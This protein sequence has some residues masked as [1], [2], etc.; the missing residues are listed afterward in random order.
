MGLSFWHLLIVLLVVLLLFG[1]GRLPKLMGDIG[2][3][4]RSLREGLKGDD[5]QKTDE[6]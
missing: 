3:G 2:K 4:V 1:P 5:A 6:K